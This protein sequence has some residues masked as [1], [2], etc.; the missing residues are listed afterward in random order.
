MGDVV[1]FPRD[2]QADLRIDRCD[3]GPLGSMVYPSDLPPHD[4]DAEGAVLSAILLDREALDRVLEILRPEHFYSEPNGRIYQ[5]AQHLV[6]DGTPV[7][8]I[9]V[10]SWLRERESLARVG[11]TAYLS[12]LADAMPTVGGFTAEAAAAQASWRDHVAVHAGTVLDRWTDRQLIATCQRVAVA[13]YGDVGDR[14]AFY[15]SVRSEFGR[16]T[17]PRVRL[18]GQHI[19]GAVEEARAHIAE[20]VGG[21]VVG[22]RYP[23]RAV[24]EMIGLLVAERQ[25]I[26]GGLSEHGKTTLA[27]QIA[28]HVAETPLDPLGFG[29]AVY[30]LSGEMPAKD[31]LQRWACSL[32]G[33]DVLRVESGFARPDEQNKISGWLDYL[34][35]LPIIIDAKPAPPAEI[36]GRVRAHKVLFE[37]GKARSHA[38]DLHPR[39]RM[40]LVVGDHA[41]DLARCMP[42][43]EERERIGDTAQ[44][45]LNEIAKPLKVATLLLSQLKRP[46][47][48]GPPPPF[49]RWP[50]KEDLFG[51][52]KL[53]TSADTVIGVQRPEL[54]MRGKIPAKWL[55]TAALCRLK[56]RFGG[57]TRRVLLAFERGQFDEHVNAAMAQAMAAAGERGETFDGDE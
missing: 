15:S 56:S 12:Q 18:A 24:E 44:G 31:L 34:A 10:A 28:Q 22:V 9:S 1:A 49:P 14:A 52:A 38:G 11:G 51:S 27:L 17:A 30:V 7:D 37:A 45:W 40:R 57:D 54:L 55:G 41:Q 8:M 20:A 13:R 39:C 2:R 33:V 50:V 4:L 21:R 35:T 42:G 36:A 5:A 29:E 32:S 26:L 46:D 25:T 16:L 53:E 19:G 6:K 3:P 48:K 43:R 23:W 47:Y